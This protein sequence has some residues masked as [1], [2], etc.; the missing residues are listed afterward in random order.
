MFLLQEKGFT[1]IFAVDQQYRNL[2]EVG[3]SENNAMQLK[4]NLLI[5][6]TA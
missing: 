2:Y 5:S 3:L 4:L 1:L 6:M